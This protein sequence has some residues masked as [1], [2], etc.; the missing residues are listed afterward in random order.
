[1]IR[2]LMT[3]VKLIEAQFSEATKRLLLEMGREEYSG[4]YF[5]SFGFWGVNVGSQ[6]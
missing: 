5:L 3:L 2:D 6:S 4:G 1:M